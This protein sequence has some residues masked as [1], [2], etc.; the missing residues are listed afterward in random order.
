MNDDVMTVIVFFTFAGGMFLAGF[1]VG[2]WW[3]Q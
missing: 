1:V 2:Y 3:G